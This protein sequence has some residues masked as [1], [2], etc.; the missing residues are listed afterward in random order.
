MNAK[1]LAAE[2][3]V[4]LVKD[5]MTVGLGTGSTSA[6][7]IESIGRKIQ[8]GL[9]VVAVASSIRSE[10]LAKTSG[11]TVVNFAE[12][13]TIDIYIDGADEVDQTLNLIKGGGGALLREK[14]LAFN[15][16]EFIVI[17]DESKLVRQFGKFLLPV[18]VTSFAIELTA[19]QLQKLGCSTSQRQINNRAYLTDNGNFII[20]CDFKKIDQPDSLHQAINSIPG[21][22][23]NGLFLNNMV[24]KIIVG[25]ESGEIKLMER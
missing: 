23:E 2:H 13:K 20:D 1:Q 4:Q 9:K 14:I 21:V 25:Y 22:I 19:K 3:A 16:K 24:S 5:G 18:E 12:L 8:Q 10:Q 17:V 6:F 7:A 11:I 15:S